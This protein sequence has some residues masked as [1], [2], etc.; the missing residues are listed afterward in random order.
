MTKILILIAC[1]AL[2]TTQALLTQNARLYDAPLLSPTEFGATVETP[3]S[4]LAFTEYS[5]L[6]NGN[7]FAVQV[8]IF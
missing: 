3:T 5:V 6:N 7:S 4:T 8:F 2:I 1:F